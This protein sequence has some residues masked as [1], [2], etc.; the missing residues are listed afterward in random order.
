RVNEERAERGVGRQVSLPEPPR[1]LSEPV[2]PLQAGAPNTIWRDPIDAGQDVDGA[3]DSEAD[4]HSQ[5]SE[6]SIQ[7]LVFADAR[8]ADQKDVGAR[9]DNFFDHIVLLGSREEPI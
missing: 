4:R 3:A 8:D 9:R 6:L 1:L 2:E 5:G 7:K